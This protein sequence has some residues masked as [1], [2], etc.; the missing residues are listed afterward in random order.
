MGQTPEKVTTDETANDGTAPY[1]SP[2][3]R[4]VDRPMVL[5][6]DDEEDIRDALTLVLSGAGFD[7]VTAESGVE[8]VRVARAGALDAAITDLRMPDQ[9]GE[10][11]ISALRAEQPSLPILVLTGYA[12]D[13]TAAECL[14][15]GAS[16]YLRKPVDIDELIARLHTVIKR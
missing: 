12:S 9:S 4:T 11:T 14:R 13:D 16:A 6:V 3:T 7:V 2:A 1:W 5:V 8:A 10:D 15:R